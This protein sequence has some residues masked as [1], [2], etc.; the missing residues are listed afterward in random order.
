MEICPCT[1]RDLIP[2]PSWNIQW[3]GWDKRKNPWTSQ[4]WILGRGKL[5]EFLVLSCLIEIKATKLVHNITNFYEFLNLQASLTG[6][7]LFIQ[8]F[9][10]N[11][12]VIVLWILSYFLDTDY[13]NDC[14][15]AFSLS[16]LTNLVS[17]VP[18]GPMRKQIDACIIF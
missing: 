18:K 14:Q 13:D 1:W 11:I 17:Y 5:I 10:W 9:P 6:S 16:N 2:L 7:I 3:A 4:L 15:L 8:L 12:S